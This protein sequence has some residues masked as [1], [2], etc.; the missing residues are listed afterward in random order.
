MT[1]RRYSKRIC[2]LG[3][4]EGERKM[5]ATIEGELKMADST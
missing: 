2:S 5:A 4:L 1:R 3:S